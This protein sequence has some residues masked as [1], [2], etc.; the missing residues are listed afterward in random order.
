MKLRIGR[1]MLALFLT[2]VMAMCAV[3]FPSADVL[4][5]ETVVSGTITEADGVKRLS[6]GSP[7]LDTALFEQG[8]E[9]IVVTK[10]EDIAYFN[11]METITMT[12][13][14][15]YREP[16]S[17]NHAFFALEG[18]DGEHITFWQNP[19]VSNNTQGRISF[20]W[21]GSQGI[22]GSRDGHKIS[23]TNYH[24]LTV[25]YVPPDANTT[26]TN[27]YFAIDGVNTNMNLT[28]LASNWY[29]KINEL[30]QGESPLHTFTIGGKGK[31][32]TYNVT[33]AN[34]GMY[35]FDGDI[36]YME[37]SSKKLNANEVV[38]ENQKC[39]DGLFEALSS[40]ITTCESTYQK[41]NEDGNYPSATWEPY[42]T[43]LTAAK[44]VT[45]ST[46]E[47]VIYNKYDALKA[48]EDALK[49]GGKNIAP[50][51]VT[52]GAAILVQG[53][54]LTMSGKDLATDANNDLLTI[55]SAE[56]AEAAA[57]NIGLNVEDGLLK[58]RCAEGYQYDPAHKETPFTVNAVVSDGVDEV[59]ASFSL[60]IEQA[61]LKLE[62]NDIEL[63]PAHDEEVMFL[64]KKEIKKLTQIEESL[65]V[66]MTFRYDASKAFNKNGEN[67][68]YL[69]EIGDSEN[70]YSEK[71]NNGLA[72]ANP[73]ARAHSS[74]ALILNVSSGTVYMNTGAWEG[75]T[76][77]T[78][79]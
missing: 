26:A 17:K 29:G 5:E 67:Y 79:R 77:W 19:L 31:N 73:P 24:K 60:Y 54:T 34:G 40:Y 45:A 74:L 41:E 23:D 1:R 10:E 13:V 48:A 71:D 68:Y 18:N 16:V 36:K 69:M 32:T 58:I 55:T 52:D 8:A 12:M 22:F 38:A 46:P 65:E 70:N 64:E 56:S 21:K 43:A 44:T 47:W 72:G 53:K 51:A 6:Y 76:D 27:V 63:D 11:E 14:F 33:A 2:V 50:T 78:F 25:S 62:Y 59:N 4:A 28:N 57:E 15:R 30:L 9:P 37:F 49:A 20:D 7:A 66:S 61:P 3:P 35:D 39:P 42:E 75:S